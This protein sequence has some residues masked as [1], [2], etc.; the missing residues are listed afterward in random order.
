[1]NQASLLLLLGIALAV[2]FY[3]AFRVIRL[4]TLLHVNERLDERT[5]VLTHEIDEHKR[6]E[7]AL[8]ESQQIIRAIVDT[9]PAR[10]FW[11]DKNLVYL[12]CN[13]PFARDA[14]FD[15][16][17]DVVG[18]DDY[19]MG[20][21]DQAELYR[22]DDREVIETGQSKLLIKEPQ[23]T[24]DG[25]TIT[26]LTNKVP[27]RNVDGEVFGMLG[28]YMDVTER[29]RAEEALRQSEARFKA[30]F[31]NARDGIAL[32]DAETK[33]F[34]AANDSFCQML[35][36]PKN[37]LLGL[38]IDAV[39]PADKLQM[40][41]QTFERQAR[42]EIDLAADMPVKRRDGSVFFADINSAP[43]KIGDKAYLLGVFRDIS[44]RKIADDKIKF[45]N[46]LL[47]A[48]LESAPDGV[49][50]VHSDPPGLSC[51]HNFLEMWS[52]PPEVE[53]SNDPSRVLATV[54]PQLTDPK[55]FEHDIR[56]LRDD[57]GA[58]VRFREVGLKDGRTVEYFGSAVE[59]EAGAPLAR[60]WFFRDITERKSAAA[61]LAQSEARFK[62]I[63]DNARDGIA[64]TDPE[65]KKFLLGNAYLYRMLGYTADEFAGL[66]MSDIHPAESM[67]AVLKEFDRHE[68]GDRRAATDVLVKR[69]NGAVFYVDINSAPVEIGGK[70]YVL[71]IF[72]DATARREA[73]AAVRKSEERYR[74]LVESTTDYIWEIDQNGRYTYYT[75]AFAGTLGYEPG[76][77]IGKTP[78]DLMPP[79]EAE[80]VAPI[81][82]PIAAAQRPFSMLEN[83]VVTKDGTEIVME[84]SGVPI[85]DENG[86]FCGYRGI[87]R[88]ITQRKRA[89]HELKARDALL[90]AVAVSAT[91]LVTAP[92]LDEAIPKALQ[93][94]SQT[95]QVDRMTVL[96]RP[97]GSG[98]CADA[99]IRLECTRPEDS[100]G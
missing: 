61:A 20:W 42:G 46:T 43:V 41:A 84:T 8:R 33:K 24:P 80:R 19:Q 32:A 89:E 23:T 22:G 30:I 31:D 68:R 10:I 96:E 57:P 60:I 45:A 5:E 62:A 71:G 48:E 76:E 53:R 14:G 26:L 9:V 34:L 78:F 92:S 98:R 74:D 88:D 39:H 38:T 40:V 54:L 69:K 21:R 85:F 75:P 59:D 16:P 55:D 44:E 52:I 90:H 56:H 58:A 25:K 29:E 27:L 87:E 66:G 86:K 1:M 15:R 91:E 72:R 36:Y 73:E 79:A 93:T 2:M 49:F 64:L 65:T 37:E 18:K 97:S 77:I 35:G 13:E 47:R 81:F 12:G 6:G 95:L 82:G 70:R 7:A 51:N 28:T 100:L 83:M 50:V 11:K 4:R 17:E 3:F 67:P 99:T 94:V 63:F